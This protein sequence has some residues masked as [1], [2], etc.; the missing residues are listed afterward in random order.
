V[1]DITGI[2]FDIKRYAIN[3]GPG[4]RTTVFFKGC[5]LRCLWCHNPES[6]SGSPQLMHRVSRCISC[7]QCIQ[8]CPESAVTRHAGISILWQRCTNCGACVHVCPAGA[9]EMVGKT[10]T[11]DAVMQ[12]VGKDIIFYDQSG[13]GVTF[14]GGEPLA[15]PE[16]L[17]ELL[18][19]C[20]QMNIHTALDTSCYAERKII[21][22]VIDKVNLF[23]CDIKHPDSAKHR[24]FVGVENTIILENIRYLAQKGKPIIIRVPVV[25]GFNDQ[26]ETIEAI[27]KLVG[28][29]KGIH[30]IDLLPYNSGGWNKAQ[31]MGADYALKGIREPDSQ[32]MRNLAKILEDMGFEVHIGG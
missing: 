17:R 3:D 11:V 7:G 19:R 15:Q 23:L 9:M 24:E 5:P 16:F 22:S 12:E 8:A 25:P 18:T 2:I 26:P 13:G 29:M 6:I 10:M 20:Q 28:Q 30:R 31:R 21:D 27:G 14:C 32:T 1:S 4:I